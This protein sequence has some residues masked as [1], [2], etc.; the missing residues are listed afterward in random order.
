MIVAHAQRAAMIGAKMTALTTALVSAMF[1]AYASG[2]FTGG[3]SAAL[4]QRLVAA[5]PFGLLVGALAGLAVFGIIGVGVALLGV[6]RVG[7]TFVYS[8]FGTILAAIAVQPAVTWLAGNATEVLAVPAGAAAITALAALTGFLS[9]I[10][11]ARG[12]KDG[13]DV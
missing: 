12:L 10:L 7:W 1:A 3:D 11:V 4:G 9:G 13:T 2:I 6:K 5:V 8:V